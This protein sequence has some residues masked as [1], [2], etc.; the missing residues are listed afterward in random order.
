MTARLDTTP[1]ISEAEFCAQILDLARIFRWRSAHFRPALTKH[2]WRTPVQGDGAGWPDLVLVRPPRIV[3]AE[4]KAAKGRL[5]PEQIEW[6]A[7]FGA[8]PGVETFEWRPKDWDQI[9]EVLR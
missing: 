2:G 4:L 9:A 3:V 1:A 6:L 8:C 5:R 7:D